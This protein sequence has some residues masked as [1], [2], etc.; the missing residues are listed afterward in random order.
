M[1]VAGGAFAA[2]G[3]TITPMIGSAAM[4]ISSVCVVLNSLRLNAGM[5]K[6]KAGKSAELTKEQ[7]SACI[8]GGACGTNG[9][10]HITDNDKKENG[11]MRTFKIEGMMCMH[12]VGRVTKALEEL[13]LKA[14]VDLG[15]GTA[16][17]EGDASDADIIAAV[18]KAG[19]KASV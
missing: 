12:C 8:A 17:V 6:S 2:L 16:T 3:F 9:G 13:G 19:Y 1:P 11:N 10:A 14:K 7:T 18:E 15:S 4:S 5:K